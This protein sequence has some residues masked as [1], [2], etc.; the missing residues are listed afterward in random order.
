MDPLHSL[1][2]I[3]HCLGGQLAI[4]PRGDFYTLVDAD[5][6]VCLPHTA[7]SVCEYGVH[8]KKKIIYAVRGTQHIGFVIH[9]AAHVFADRYHPDH[10]KCDEWAWLGW[11]IVVAR[12]LGVLAAW[13]RQNANYCLGDG[14]DTGLGKGK[15]WGVLSAHERR[16]VVTDRL[17]HAKKI[18]VLSECGAL[19]SVR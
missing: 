14:L 5:D 11:E 8:W 18:G 2:R 19:R 12:R 10:D 16:A 15:D 4:V 13:S 1:A 9:E 6:D 7:G 17:A 3:C